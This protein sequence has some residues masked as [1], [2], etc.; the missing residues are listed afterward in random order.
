MELLCITLGSWAA[1]T[2]AAV[3]SGFLVD[4]VVR[5]WAR[6]HA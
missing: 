2:A 6:A 5:G 3:L 4:Q 1:F